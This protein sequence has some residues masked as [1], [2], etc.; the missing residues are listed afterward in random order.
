MFSFT[1]S[2]RSFN[3][4]H[5]LPLTRF[6][7][8]PDIILLKEPIICPSSRANLVIH[9]DA[10][11]M[12][13]INFSFSNDSFLTLDIHFF[14]NRIRASKSLSNSVIIKPF[15]CTSISFKTIVVLI[16]SQAS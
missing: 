16:F 9:S 6:S 2:N 7:S 4:K 10:P 13:P 5:A 12:I 8:K 3:S 15:S 1:G 14:A 11:S